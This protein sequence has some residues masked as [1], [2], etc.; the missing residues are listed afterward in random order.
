MMNLAACLKPAHAGHVHIHKN[1][2]RPLANDHLDGFLAVLGLDDVVAATRKSSLQD[3]TDLRLVV[4]HQDGCVGRSY[5]SACRSVEK[6]NKGLVAVNIAFA[7]VRNE[8]LRTPEGIVRS[9]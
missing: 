5:T 3:A 1:Q 9:S 6:G 7:M 4:H 8:Q 2:S